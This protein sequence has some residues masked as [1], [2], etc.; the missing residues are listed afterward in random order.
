MDSD[1]YLHS[2][3][4]WKQSGSCSDDDTVLH[5]TGKQALALLQT[6]ASVIPVPL[7]QD[8]IGIAMKIIEVYEVRRILQ[9]GKAT[10][11]FAYMS[12][13]RHQLFKNRSKS[14]KRGS[15]IS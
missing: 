4:V 15:P 14:C 6:A 10:R 7:L 8:V 5:A 11:R 9:D 12:I 1:K 3:V 13:R 2:E